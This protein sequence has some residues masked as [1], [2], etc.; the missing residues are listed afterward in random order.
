MDIGH[1][2]GPIVAG[3]L[4]GALGF[5]T[6]FAIIAGLVLLAAAGF[7]VAVRGERPAGAVA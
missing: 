3:V 1:A 7:Q 2:S 6:A 5:Q 4:I